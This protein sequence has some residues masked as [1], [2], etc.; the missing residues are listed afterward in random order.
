MLSLEKAQEILYNE[1]SRLLLSSREV[2]SVPLW[3]AG[4]RILAQNII[5]A[6]NVPAFDRSPVDG[7]ALKSADTLKASAH[8]P[9]CLRIIDTVAAG[10]CSKKILASGTAIKIFTGAPLPR[11]ANCVIKKEEVLESAAGPEK[12]ATVLVKRPVEEGESIAYE[13]EDISA[14]DQLFASGTVLT[15]AHIGVLASLGIDPVPVYK[16]PQI[17]I[18]STGNELVDVRSPLQ[19]GQLRASNLYTLAGIIRQ[20]GGSPVNLGI[21]KDRAEDVLQVY[22][23][24]ARLKLPLVLSTGGTA[25]GDYDVIKEAMN[26]AAAERLFNK[27]AIRPGAPLVVSVKEGQMLIG[28]SGNPAG[29]TVAA[30]LLIYP[31]ISRLAGSKKQLKRTAGKL[32]A[33]LFRR[34]GL[35][36]FLWANCYEQ[37]GSLHVTP[38]EKQFCGAV[39]NF[40]TSNCLIEVPPGKCDLATGAMVDIWKLPGF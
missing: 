16:K 31:I 30:L 24:A 34:G 7:F 25:S 33:P 19:L 5:A 29:A 22:E 12:E 17:G 14:G 26:M 32:D 9:V 3:E 20:A 1:L 4:E 10:S 11:G 8:S 13:G 21:I 39:K 37:N 2:E 18:F 36:G 40:A 15:S 28:L 23:K 6:E 27:V 38:F 35:R